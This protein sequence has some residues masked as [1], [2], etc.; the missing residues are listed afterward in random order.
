MGPRLPI[1]NI[2]FLKLIGI[3]LSLIFVHTVHRPRLLEG[4]V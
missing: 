4:V 3:H 1:K 2:K